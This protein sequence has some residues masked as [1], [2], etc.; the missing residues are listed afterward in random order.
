[1][2]FMQVLHSMG[3]YIWTWRLEK[4]DLSIFMPGLMKSAWSWMNMIG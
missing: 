1:M 4:T 3:A 2:S